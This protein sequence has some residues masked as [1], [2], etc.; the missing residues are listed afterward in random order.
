MLPLYD[1]SSDEY[2]DMIGDTW[3]SLNKRTDLVEW[4]DDYMAYSREEKQNLDYEKIEPYG[5][6]LFLK[7][8]LDADTHDS[9]FLLNISPQE[10]NQLDDAGNVV[11]NYTYSTHYKPYENVLEAVEDEQNIFITQASLDIIESLKNRNS[12][13]SSESSGD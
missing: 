2:K 6:Q 4:T 10:W 1:N 11:V 8:Y 3:L 13:D 9:F 5:N 7:I 12:S